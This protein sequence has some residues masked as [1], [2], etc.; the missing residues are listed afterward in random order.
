MRS[1]SLA[2][3]ASPEPTA[4]LRRVA[5]HANRP[6]MSDAET[7]SDSMRA[8]LEA[9][10]R[11]MD[12]DGSEGEPDSSRPGGTFSLGLIALA[13]WLG[14]GFGGVLLITLNDWRLGN[15]PVWRSAAL[16]YLLLLGSIAILT[17]VAP[18]GLSPRLSQLVKAGREH[19][20]AH[21]RRVPA[22]ELTA[23]HRTTR[24]PT[25]PVCARGHRD[26]V[27]PGPGCVGFAGVLA[28]ALSCW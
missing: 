16:F 20:R 6:A 24:I 15:R 5:P 13:S 19:R 28:C 10:L 9:E 25:G 7:P 4:R 12:E 23:G 11:P 18:H 2:G 26:R 3:S 14:V 8:R 21:T 17:L 22:A 27:A 1:N